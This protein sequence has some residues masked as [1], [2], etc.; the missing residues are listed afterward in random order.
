MAQPTSSP[1][2]AYRGNAPEWVTRQRRKC[3]FPVGPLRDSAE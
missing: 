2:R 1:P 3:D